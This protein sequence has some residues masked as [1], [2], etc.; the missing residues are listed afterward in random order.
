MCHASQSTQYCILSHTVVLD[1]C[2]MKIIEDI[3]LLYED[4]NGKFSNTFCFEIL[5]VLKVTYNLNFFFQY[6]P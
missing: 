5:L 4:H 6:S 1:N 2:S 3:C